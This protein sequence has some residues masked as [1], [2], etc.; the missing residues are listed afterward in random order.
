[1][2][3]LRIHA[4]WLA[5]VPAAHLV[6]VVRGTCVEPLA[7]RQLLA[8]LDFQAGRAYDTTW[9]CDAHTDRPFF[10]ARRDG[11]RHDLARFVP[12]YHCP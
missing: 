6:V 12:T 5:R 2:C 1:M 3:P 4:M 8:V 10:G 7:A 11:P 9:L